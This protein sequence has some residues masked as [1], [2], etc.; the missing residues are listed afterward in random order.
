[1]HIVRHA[2]ADYAAQIDRA[3]ATSSLFDPAIEQ[4]TRAIV[5]AVRERG[6]A[7]LTEFT[8]RFDGAKLRPEQF[9]VTT[10]DQMHASLAA[11][12]PLRAAI[13]DLATEPRPAASEKLAGSKL[14]WR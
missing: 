4:R 5:D 12:E 13:A 1:M 11:D 2:D 6:D 3:A 14:G 9:A 7:A 10:A 8:E